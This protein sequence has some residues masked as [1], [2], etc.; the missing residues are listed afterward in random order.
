MSE[1]WD[2][3]SAAV[4][5][6]AVRGFLFANVSLAE[7][8]RTVCSYQGQRLKPLADL[9]FSS[10]VA[11]A[12]VPDSESQPVLLAM[13]VEVAAGRTTRHELRLFSMNAEGNLQLL[14][15]EDLLR[16]VREF[17]FHPSGRFLYV[18]DTADT[19]FGYALGAGGRLELVE[20]TDDAGGE[21]MAITLP[22][23]ES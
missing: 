17:S 7:G 20:S 11:G 14:D 22:S 4:P 16:E 18:S 10:S 12:F 13:G 8:G 9:G 19:L 6:V 15:S 3:W 2:A 1:T 5:L 23:P 21:S